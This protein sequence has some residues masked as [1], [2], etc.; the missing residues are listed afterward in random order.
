[1]AE[2]IDCV[3]HIDHENRIAKC[4][5]KIEDLDNRLT[6]VEKKQALTDKEIQSAVKDI[7]QYMKAMND[8]VN[9]IQEGTSKNSEEIQAL[10]NKMDNRE[11]DLDELKDLKS[12][13]TQIDEEGKL[14]IRLWLK[15]NFIYVAMGVMA[16]VYLVDK[17][18]K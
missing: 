1:M 2:K 15:E 10:S 14:N 4:E 8:T 12:K 16:I 18:I 6:E 17:F 5:N 3:Y 7:A 13:V 9:K 11:K